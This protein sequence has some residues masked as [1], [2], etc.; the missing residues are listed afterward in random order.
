MNIFLVPYTWLRHTQV[1][2]ASAAAALLAWWAVLT[3]FVVFGPFWTLEWD[4]ALF[5]GSCGGAIAGASVLSEGTLR[6]R[7]LGQRLGYTALAALISGVFTFGWYWG[8][9]FVSAPMLFPEAAL[10]DVSDPSLVSL[11]YRLGAFVMAG[12]CTAIGPVVVRRGRATVSHLL[13]GAAAGLSAGA[14]WHL[15]NYM[16]TFD[17]YLGAALSAVAW[18]GVFGLLSWGIPDELYAGWVRVLSGHRFGH[19]IP[20]DAPDRA[21]KERF[22]GHFPRGLD[23]W[24]PVEGGAMELHASFAVDDKQRYRA[25]GLTLQATLLRRFLERIDLRYDPRRPAPLETRVR[26]GDRLAVG[27]GQRQSVVEFLMLPREER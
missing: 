11:R 16:L 19:R 22:I 9:T 15:F 20:I 24:L 25:R 3:W 4:G 6:R 21:P 18:G 5:F 23:L 13:S 27:E 26:S 17:L 7:P 10:E 2:L 1:A 12:L 14:T 8:F